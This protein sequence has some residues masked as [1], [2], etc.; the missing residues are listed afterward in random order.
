MGSNILGCIWN[1]NEDWQKGKSMKKGK[2]KLLAVIG[3]ILAAA[4]YYYVALP[5][6]NI[7]SSDFWMFL[8]V[9]IIAAALI[10]VKRKRLNRYDLKESKGLKAIVEIGRAHV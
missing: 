8:I 9:L 4:I 5:A 1:I 2:M 3:V 6:I 7:H 10:Y